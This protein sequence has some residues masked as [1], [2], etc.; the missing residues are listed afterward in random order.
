MQSDPDQDLNCRIRLDRN[1]ETGHVQHGYL[2]PP[3]LLLGISYFSV[4]E[5]STL[6]SVSLLPAGSRHLASGL[7]ASFCVSGLG[8]NCR[9]VLLKVTL[10]G[11][12]SI[13]QSHFRNPQSVI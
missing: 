13:L 8:C 1:P 11:R 4:S 10:K 12:Q 9:Y 2:P 7:H 3:L 5:L 6:F